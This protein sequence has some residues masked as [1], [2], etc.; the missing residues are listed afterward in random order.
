VVFS[1][2]P[3]PLHRPLGVVFGAGRAAAGRVDGGVG[4]VG[5]ERPGAE[6]FAL[7][8]PPAVANAAGRFTR[9]Q[10]ERG[11]AAL[12]AAGGIVVAH[13][14]VD[15]A[16]VKAL[17]LAAAR[18]AR[19]PHGRIAVLARRPSYGETAGGAIVGPVGVAEVV[20]HSEATLAPEFSRWLAAP[21]A[22]AVSS[23]RG[24]VDGVRVSTLGIAAG[25]PLPGRSEGVT[26]LLLTDA[27]FA[28][29][30]LPRFAAEL[31]ERSFGQVAGI[32]V[33][34]RDD[35]IVI[36]ATGA[37]GT[38][39]LTLDA[40]GGKTLLVGAVA[41][42]QSLVQQ[43]LEHS[44]PANAG[45]AAG[46]ALVVQITVSGALDVEQAAAVAEAIAVE[47]PA[48]DALA[49]AVARIAAG[50]G[51]QVERSKLFTDWKRNAARAALRV[52]LGLAQASATRW[53]AF[54]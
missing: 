4:W 41:V 43:L 2:D 37:A 48:P 39:P 42:A 8:P 15:D 27:T 14:E 17:A 31:A 26:A 29:N 49:D 40:L 38:S 10:Q 45:A 13:G 23:A 35:A 21:R 6:L 12:E 50:T 52:D 5:I 33:P 54:A 25:R 47:R 18:A 7:V 9:A 19:R 44:D 34:H 22:A 32:H 24:V 3:G 1:L 53:T 51:V 36:V 11:G 28:T 20:A 30:A 46:A 16:R